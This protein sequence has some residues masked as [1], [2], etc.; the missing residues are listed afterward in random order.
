[1][2]L[3]QEAVKIFGKSNV[4]ITIGKNQSKNIDFSRIMYHLAP[5]GVDY[6]IA[7]NTT[8]SDYCK[9]ND[10]IYIVR[11][12]R[13]TADA[14]YELKLDFMNKE[15]YPKIQTMFFPTKDIFSNV[16]SSSIIELLNYNKFEVVKKYMNEDSMYRFHNK[17]PEFVVFFGRSFIGKTHYLKNVLGY[18]NDNLVEVDK[19]LWEIFGECYG[20]EEKIK[21]SEESRKIVYGGGKLDDLIEKY[22]T[23]TFWELFFGYIR[24]HF[25]K[26]TFFLKNME[27]E[28]EV[29]LLDF[30][31]IGAYW[32]SIGSFLRGKLFLIR[33]ENSEQNRLKLLETCG[34]VDRIK[35]L[36]FN[37]R[38]PTYFDIQRRIDE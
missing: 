34:S 26:S 10:I 20:Q 19:I 6:D 3:Y 17:S 23:D 37:Y 31:A 2:S 13:N 22:S 28:R 25:R 21:I 32:S 5:Y 16:S 7:A 35:Y 8:L 4:K 27:V 11:G 14:E 30:P 12:I 9:I 24:R 18:K 33:L 36:D 38:E 1:M 15:I 29:F